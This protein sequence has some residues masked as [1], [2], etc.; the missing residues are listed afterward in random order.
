MSLR[1]SITDYEYENGRRYHA[2][3]AGSYPMPND[4]VDLYLSPVLILDSDNVVL[5]QLESDRLDMFHH[6]MTLSL[7]GRLHLAPLDKGMKRVLDI[8]TGTGIWAIEM[9]E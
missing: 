1:P 7:N 6:A 5:L 4:E 3:R 2:Y 8:G 9:G